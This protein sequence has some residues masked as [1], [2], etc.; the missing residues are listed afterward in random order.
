[1]RA[2]IERYK[3]W[4]KRRYWAN[5]HLEFIRVMIGQDARWLSAHPQGALLMARYEKMIREDWY[6]IPFQEISRFRQDIGWCPH[7][8]KNKRA[9]S[10]GEQP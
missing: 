10:T 3:E 9:A 1:M 6:T 4:R 8:P 7:D 2:L 5:R